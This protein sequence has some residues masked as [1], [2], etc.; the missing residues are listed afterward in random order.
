MLLMT[1]WWTHIYSKFNY[2]KYTTPMGSNMCGIFFYKPV[3]P[4]VSY[5]SQASNDADNRGAKGIFLFV[6]F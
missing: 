3:I 5:T 4:K 1:T 2:G 6:R